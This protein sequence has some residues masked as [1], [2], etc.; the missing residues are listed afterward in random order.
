MGLTQER[1]WVLTKLVSL[2]K[3]RYAEETVFKGEKTGIGEVRYKMFT[4]KI[5]WGTVSSAESLFA[6][7]TIYLHQTEL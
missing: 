6:N 4:I 5:T 7:D 1:F 2:V 3:E